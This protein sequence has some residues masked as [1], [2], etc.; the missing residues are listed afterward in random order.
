MSARTIGS[1]LVRER[2]QKIQLR[3]NAQVLLDGFLELAATF[4]VAA[5]VLLFAAARAGPLGFAAVFWSVLPGAAALAWWSVRRSRASWL[6]LESAA[7]LADERA[8]L[9][10]RLASVLALEARPR[11]SRLA[12]VVVAQ[13]LRLAEA[14]DPGK[15][16]PF[17]FPRNLLAFAAA[18]VLLGI[19]LAIGSSP[20][21]PGGVVLVERG[22][23]RG[24]RSTSSAFRD[25]LP[26]VAGAVEGQRGGPSGERTGEPPSVLSQTR[27]NPGDLGGNQRFQSASS[28]PQAAGRDKRS[29]ARQS[30]DPV[31]ESA[32]SLLRRALGMRPQRVQV[33]RQPPAPDTNPW[34]AARHGP[35][36]AQKGRNEK[37]ANARHDRAGF[38]RRVAKRTDSRGGSSRATGKTGE[39]APG[40]LFAERTGSGERTP[41]R[42]SL[43]LWSVIPRAMEPEPQKPDPRRGDGVSADLREAPPADLSGDPMESP[44]Y[45]LPPSPETEELMR[46]LFSR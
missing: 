30:L 20:R 41:G 16:A 28:R 34:E 14:W 5:A 2:L 35:G 37:G 40:G 9:R 13:A 1:E 12:H 45:R 36:S 27:R 26:A 4:L 3:H 42:F 25:D 43:R 17:R 19:V 38:E 39:K 6:G 15:I 11:R 33:A 8:S 32:R 31:S 29:T 44:L 22:S 7:R 18:A 10:D 21:P 23:I 46:L 24:P